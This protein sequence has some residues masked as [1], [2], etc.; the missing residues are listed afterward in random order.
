MFT[1]A[2]RF[3]DIGEPWIMTAPLIAMSV[4][5]AAF[6]LLTQRRFDRRGLW[7]VW[8]P[9]AMAATAFYAWLSHS[10]NTS[11]SLRLGI[12]VMPWAWVPVPVVVTAVITS[13]VGHVTKSS[14]LRFAIAAVV[15]ALLAILGSYPLVLSYH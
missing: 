6:A 1:I 14:G 15:F 12:L 9:S 13:G 3:R 7:A 5:L 8:L 4:A 10:E 11:L 2:M